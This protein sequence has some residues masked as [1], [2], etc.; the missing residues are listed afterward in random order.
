MPSTL[1]I[2]VDVFPREERAKA[3]GIW[4][5]ATAFG[6]PLGM[7][8]GGWLVDRF[9]WGS[10][11]LINIPV[12]GAALVASR[13]LVPE[14]RDPGAGRID[15]VGALISIGALVALIYTLIEAPERGWGNPLTIVGFAAA[16]VFTVGFVLFELRVKNPMLDMR[17]FRNARLSAGVTSI[18]IAFMVMLGMMF[19]LTQYLQFARGYNGLETGFRFTPLALGFMVGAPASA[20]L[21]SKLGAKWIMGVGFLILAGAMSGLA[22][23]DGGSAYWIIGVVMFI[24]S[25]GMANTM[26]PATD[27]VMAALPEEHAGVGSALNDTVRQLG[28]ALGIAV[29][30]SIFNSIYSSRVADAV[31]NRR[32]CENPFS[33]PHGRASVVTPRHARS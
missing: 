20:V 10:V 17:F 29:F 4:A 21:V 15:Y 18:G 30:G 26:A 32:C 9:F 7:I 25:L 22:L 5:A 6:L 2:I 13:F 8:L 19:I 27:A 33:Y 3:I 12:A 28:G 31:V 1:S 16:V 14:S 23:V 11:F 24:F